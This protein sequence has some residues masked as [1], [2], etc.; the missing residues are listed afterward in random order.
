MS[1]FYRQVRGDQ[2]RLYTRFQFNS[3]KRRGARNKAIQEDRN[4]MSG[5][6]EDQA[7]QT[8]DLKPAHL[9]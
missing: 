7:G 6:A 1:G 8:A 3:Q 9:G 4:A 2:K 5:R